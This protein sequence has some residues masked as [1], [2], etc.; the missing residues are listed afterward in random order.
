MITEDW[1][2]HLIPLAGS[3]PGLTFL[4]IGVYEAESAVWL[5][6]K[7]LTAV[8]D[9]YVGIDA[10]KIDLM[11]KAQFPR[12][13]IGED[14]LRG[15][16]LRARRALAPYGSKAVVLRGRSADVLRKDER[17]D[18]LYPGNIDI[19]YIDGSRD[20]PTVHYD[21]Q[22]IWPLMPIGGVIIWNDFR[23]LRGVENTARLGI[24]SFLETVEGKFKKLWVKRQL[25]IRKTAA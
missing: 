21:S 12:N 7:V 5:L 3:R 15:V 6:E 24:V 4:E 22:L 17:L 20:T 11:P 1:E 25:G 19:A 18:L 13:A 14:K 16:E 8:D 9:Q 2:K 23:L 10:W